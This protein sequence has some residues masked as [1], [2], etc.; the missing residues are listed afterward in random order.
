HHGASQMEQGDDL[1]LLPAVQSEPQKDR[2]RQD[3]HQKQSVLV[4]QHPVI[5]PDQAAGADGNHE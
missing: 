4:D 1:G 2:M 3:C 5:L